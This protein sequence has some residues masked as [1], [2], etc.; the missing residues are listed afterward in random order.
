MC[1]YLKQFDDHRISVPEIQQNR[2]GRECSATFQSASGINTQRFHHFAWKEHGVR[3][4]GVRER[5]GGG[6]RSP[7]VVKQY[8]DCPDE[9]LLAQ[10]TRPNQIHQDTIRIEVGTCR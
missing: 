7:Q 4:N 1:A 10:M 6:K 5:V 8:K 9:I 3:D 2:E